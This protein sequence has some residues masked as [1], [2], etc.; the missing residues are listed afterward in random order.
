MREKKDYSKDC[1]KDDDNRLNPCFDCIHFCFP[2][3]C[4]IDEQ[5][6]EDKDE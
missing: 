4:M 3:G 5:T 6:T 1:N 2:I